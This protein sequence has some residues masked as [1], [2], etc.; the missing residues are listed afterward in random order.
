MKKRVLF[1]C[2]SNNRARRMHTIARQMTDIESA[3]APSYGD[4]QRV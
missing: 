4:C 2:G 1:I 3:F